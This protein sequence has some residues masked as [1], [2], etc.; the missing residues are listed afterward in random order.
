MT[1][2]IQRIIMLLSIFALCSTSC[3]EDFLA[4]TPDNLISFEEFLA[5]PESAQE[6]LNS[7][8]AA[9]TYDGFLGGNAWILSELMADN[10]DGELLTNGDYRA[11]YTRTTDIF[12]GT[13]RTLMHDAGK[14]HARVNYLSDNIDLVPNLAEADK[15]QI[16]SEGKF[17]RAIS[18]FELVRFFA[19]PYGYTSDNSHPG[20]SIHTDFDQSPKPRNTVGEV[21]TQIIADLMDAA[22]NLPEQNNGYATS[23]AAKGMLAKVYFQ[24]NDFQ[25]AYAMAD[26]V[27]ENS[28][29]V[30]D[31][32]L[33]ARFSQNGTSEA[34]FQLISVDDNDNAGNKLANDYRVSPTGVATLYMSSDA[35]DAATN[36]PNDA[37]AQWFEELA[38]GSIVFHKFVTNNQSWMQVPLVHLTELKLIRAE[39]AA[40]QES[41]LAQA[42][43]DLNDLRSRAAVPLVA[44]SSSA[45]AIVE[46]ARAD[47]R[48]ELIG[49]GNRLHEL[50]RQAVH[51]SPNLKIRGANWDCAGMVCQLPDNELQGNPDMELNPQGGCN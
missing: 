39:S 24:M 34:I 17:L 49:E 4:T 37:R 33:M 3:S 28:G 23:W 29:A 40:E 50:K 31:A 9:L 13:T 8:Y 21:Y 38:T 1:K 20:I 46:F 27:I 45:Q 2:H 32:D 35:F 16:L 42:I 22:N 26:E 14:V 44:G 51:D 25:N 7:A 15:I 36:A 47:R 43:D 30:L 5:S 19:Q 41:N 6:L 48:I 11:H 18:H 12:L 10:L